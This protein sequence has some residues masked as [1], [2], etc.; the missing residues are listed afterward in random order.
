[1]SFNVFG[2]PT[3]SLNYYIEDHGRTPKSFKKSTEEKA[4]HS[5]GIWTHASYINHSCNSNARRAFIGNMMIVRASRDIEAGTEVTFWYCIP[6]GIN[7]KDMQDKLKHWSFS[8]GCDIC[9]DIRATDGVIT[10][11]RR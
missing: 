3:S 10:A 5:V 2:C 7:T 11:K 1:M 8:C 6:D 9:L 4:H